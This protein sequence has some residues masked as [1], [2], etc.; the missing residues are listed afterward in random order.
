M[1]RRALGSNRGKI[2]YQLQVAN[3]TNKNDI[4]LYKTE[5]DK[6]SYH[7]AKF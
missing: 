5:A 6:I 2:P 1:A 7:A 4:E 3:G